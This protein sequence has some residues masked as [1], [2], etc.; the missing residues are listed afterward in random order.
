MRS[1]RMST[2]KV[3]KIRDRIYGKKHGLDRVCA[4]RHQTIF[5]W[6]QQV[7]KETWVG[8]AVKLWVSISCAGAISS[9]K[10]TRLETP[11]QARDLIFFKGFT[12]EQL[13]CLGKGVF[14]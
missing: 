10:H 3:T 13:D 6:T 14:S 5:F 9:V 12:R 4:T 11:K 8:L 2:R 1:I 7:H